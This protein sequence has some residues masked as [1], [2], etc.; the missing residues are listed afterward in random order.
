MGKITFKTTTKKY[1][2][3]EKIVL[4]VCALENVVMSHERGLTD[5]VS[6]L[7]LRKGGPSFKRL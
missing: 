1:H 7:T 5:E 3:C 6:D 4:N 2:L